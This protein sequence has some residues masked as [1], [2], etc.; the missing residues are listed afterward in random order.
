MQ[1]VSIGSGAVH[2][3]DRLLRG[4][5]TDARHVR[6]GATPIRVFLPWAIVLGALHGSFIAWFAI[7]GGLPGAWL[8]LLYVM[9]KLPALFL[10]TLGVT[11]PSLYVFNSLMGCGLGFRAMLRLLVATVVVNLALAASLGPILAFFTV[12]TTSYTFIVLLNVGLLAVAGLV[13][14]GFL[15]RTLQRLQDAERSESNEPANSPESLKAMFCIWILTYAL[16]GS[17]MGWL[18]RPFIG[19]PGTELTFLRP[20]SGSFAEAV[21]NSTFAPGAPRR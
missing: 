15:L 11:F 5:L 17:Q 18:L 21:W 4:Q 19:H 16:V 1:N 13:S 3:L 2:A 7:A 8:H 14:V 9:I 12:S 20:R 6:T 10:L